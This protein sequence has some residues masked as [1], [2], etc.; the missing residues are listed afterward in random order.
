MALAASGDS[1][2]GE[3]AEAVRALIREELGRAFGEAAMKAAKP[4]E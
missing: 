2:A 3:T 4:E 1:Q